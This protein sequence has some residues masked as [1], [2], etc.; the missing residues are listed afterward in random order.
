M[1]ILLIAPSTGKWR[2]IGRTRLFNGRTFRFSLLSL[3]TVAAET[4]ADVEVRIVDEQVEDIPWDAPVDLVGIT[5]MTAAA[6]RAYR[7]AAR[8]RERGVAVVLGGMH[9]TL[10]PDEAAEH[11][12]AVVAG[13]AEGVWANVVADARAGCLRGIYRNPVPPDLR[14]LKPIPRH[15]LDRGR[16]STVQSIQATRGCPHGCN[17]CSV[18]AYHARMHRRRP[19]PDV[20]REIAQLPGRFFVF[21]DDNLPADREYARDLFQALV[22]LKKR[23]ITQATLSVAEDPA[24][25]RLAADAGCIGLFVGLETFNTAN[26]DA[27]EKSCN[28]VE[29][30]REAIDCLHRHGIGIEAGIMFGFPED[31][32]SAFQQTLRLLDEV[33][34]DA[35]LVS[36]F[37]PL[38]GTPKFAA[39]HDRILDWNW[40]HYDFDHVVFDPRGMSAEALEAGQAWITR[41]FYRPWRILRRAW[42]HLLRP[43][44][45]ACLPYLVALN[46]AFY[47]RVVQWHVRGWNPALED[48]VPGSERQPSPAPR[49]VGGPTV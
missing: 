12:D 24:F 23:W 16:Y 18:S 48:R 45:W 26:L 3:L 47:G 21:V 38:P 19:V 10:V 28:R 15:L 40:E 7:I 32:P 13:D 41:E 8:F 27:A 39:M 25:V 22:P 1:K 9:P 49:L 30:Y 2:T 17:F 42:R 46:V 29:R 4:P 34:V 33:E 44:S 35:I 11:A 6:P 43:R 5:C 20:V 31:R 37:T 14:N 36:L